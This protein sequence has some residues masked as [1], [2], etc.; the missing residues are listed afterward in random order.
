M[1]TEDQ[2][3][4]SFPE[5]SPQPG[6]GILWWRRPLRP[7][8]R[9]VPAQPRG[10]RKRHVRKYAKGE[11]GPDISFYFRGPTGKLNLRAQNLTTFLQ[12]A[13]G[14]DDETWLF[15][16]SRADY[17]RWVRDIIKDE[18]LAKR[19]AEIERQSGPPAES[20]RLVAA[21]V[22]ERYTAPA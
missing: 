9:L 10:E 3:G 11:L 2:I 18:D 12:L 21:A 5:Q 15:H 6:E 22:D 20:R 14:I 13:E 1:H 7:P 16:L 19:I 4:L 8:V 17:S